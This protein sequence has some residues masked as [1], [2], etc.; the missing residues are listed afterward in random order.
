MRPGD[1]LARIGGEEFLIALPATP[2]AAAERQARRLCD[3]IATT[4]VTL[5]DGRSVAVTL[6]IGLAQADP[7]SLPERVIDTA[8]R[9]LMAAKSQGRNRVIVGRSAA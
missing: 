5:R 1:L 6:S 7:G 3:A 2:R 8:D 9:A 4:P